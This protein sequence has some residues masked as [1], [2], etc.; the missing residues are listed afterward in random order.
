MKLYNQ[1]GLK[2]RQPGTSFAVCDA[3][4]STVDTTLYTVETMSPRLRLAEERESSCELPDAKITGRPSNK[5]LT[6]T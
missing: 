4:G 6:Y 1:V 2:L 3:G 5:Q